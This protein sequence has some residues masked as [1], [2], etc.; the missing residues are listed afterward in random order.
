VARDA[1]FG[2]HAK[3]MVGSCWKDTHTRRLL[4]LRAVTVY[5]TRHL[6]LG[7]SA[8]YCL[9]LDRAAFPPVLEV[10]TLTSAVGRETPL[11]FC[12]GQRFQNKWGFQFS[13]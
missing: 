2:Q 1:G 13:Y 12:L 5:P 8:S 6:T 4:I 3:C 10:T 11:H 9:L 7:C